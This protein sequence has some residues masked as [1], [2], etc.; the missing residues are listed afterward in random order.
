MATTH[1]QQGHLSA[2]AHVCKAL[3]LQ[4]SLPP[5]SSSDVVKANLIFQSQMNQLNGDGL[6]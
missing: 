5:A 4:P 1:Q 6:L 2:D 3:L